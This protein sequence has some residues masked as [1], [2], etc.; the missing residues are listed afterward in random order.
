MTFKKR[1]KCVKTWKGNLVTIRVPCDW[2]FILIQNFTRILIS[3]I[4]YGPY[5]YNL[6]PS[7]N[8]YLLIDAISNMLDIILQAAA[9]FLQY[10]LQSFLRVNP[11]HNI[12]LGCTMPPEWKGDRCTKQL[13]S[14][15]NKFLKT[16]D[17]KSLSEEVMF[18]PRTG[19]C[20]TIFCA[21]NTSELVKAP[22]CNCN[23]DGVCDWTK[24][25]DC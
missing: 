2:I 4:L 19:K 12:F 15:K 6:N 7:H 18:T 5:S 17:F 11:N 1:D 8:S 3:T 20:K 13:N 24:E 14:N 22:K 9:W 21:N 10:F 25:P 16:D 23:N